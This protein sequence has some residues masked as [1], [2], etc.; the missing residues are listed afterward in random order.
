[1]V[2]IKGVGGLS[3][4]V[5]GYGV[6]LSSIKRG[7]TDKHLALR[8]ESST[9][10]EQLLVA[11]VRSLGDVPSPSE[12]KLIGAFVEAVLVW[13]FGNYVEMDVS[14]PELRD[15]LSQDV[16]QAADFREYVLK[17]IGSMQ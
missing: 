5:R 13:E 11:R 4:I 9:S 8:A 2:D 10:L 1:M 7:K 17:L 12:E 15:R 6:A 16:Y 14:Y 3:R